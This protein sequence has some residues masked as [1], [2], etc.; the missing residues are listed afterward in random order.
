METAL[1]TYPKIWTS[2]SDCGD[3]AEKGL[4]RMAN[5]AAPY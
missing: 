2:P 1:H 3:T 5:R 4:L